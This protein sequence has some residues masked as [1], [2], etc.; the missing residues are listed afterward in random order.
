MPTD[1]NIRPIELKDLPA[2][3]LVIE[4]N[5]LFPSDL[6]NDMM[7][8]YFNNKNSNDLWFTYEADKPVAIAYCA[9]E[10][11][12]EG[13][14][15]LYLIAVHPQYQGKGLGTSILQYIEQILAAGGERLLLIETSGLN[16]F[17][18][19]REFYRR[20]GYQQEA[21]IREF[22]QAGEDKIVFRKLLIDAQ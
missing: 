5:D 8:D 7:S 2:L 14:W 20:C 19:T 17:E 4:A 13:T 6:L 10:R 12:T 16:N 11:M 22:Y 9:P 18:G 15:N 1:T 21:R 3:K